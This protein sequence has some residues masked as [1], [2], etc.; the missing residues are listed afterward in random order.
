MVTPNLERYSQQSPTWMVY[1][2]NLSENKLF[3]RRTPLLLHLTEVRLRAKKIMFK[4]NSLNSL[5]AVRHLHASQSAGVRAFTTYLDCRM[6]RMKSNCRKAAM[7]TQQQHIQVDL[8]ISPERWLCET[9]R[10]FKFVSCSNSEGITLE[11]ELLLSISPVKWFWLKFR[12]YCFVICPSSGGIGPEI[13]FQP[14]GI[15]I[16]LMH[17]PTVVSVPTNW[18]SLKAMNSRLG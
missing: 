4:L 15:Y 9:L 2:F 17:F 3:R 10:T 5:R 14:I 13:L 6:G 8:G 16:M 11:R 7:E 18:L 1:L 12:S